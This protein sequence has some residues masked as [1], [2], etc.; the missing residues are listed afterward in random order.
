MVAANRDPSEFSNPHQFNPGRESNKHIAFGGGP[1]ICVGQWLAR[2]E[3]DVMIR[4]M[5]ENI[6]QIKK[7]ENPRWLTSNFL[8]GL[9]HHFMEV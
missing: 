3:N 1:H 5:L 8:M 9:K 6:N 4:T 2:V 7:F